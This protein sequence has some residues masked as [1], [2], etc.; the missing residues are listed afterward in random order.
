VVRVKVAVDPEG[1]LRSVAAAGHAGEGRAG[2]DLSCAAVSSLLRSVARLLYRSEGLQVA[3]E[4]ARPGELT[5]EV[6]GSSAGRRQWLRGVTDVLLA[7]LSDLREE[8]PGSIGLEV[9]AVGEE[10]H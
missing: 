1:C 10:E 6:L 9:K 8:R 4:A 5:L 7:G 3:G 2:E